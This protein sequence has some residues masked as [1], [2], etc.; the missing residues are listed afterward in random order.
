MFINGKFVSR[1]ICEVLFFRVIQFIYIEDWM[2]FS[3][4]FFNINGDVFVGMIKGEE[5]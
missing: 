3:V 5:G 1:M 4:Y 2:V